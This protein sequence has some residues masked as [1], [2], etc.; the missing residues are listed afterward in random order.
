MGCQRNSNFTTA[1]GRNSRNS[2]GRSRWATCVVKNASM[3]TAA[4]EM[5]SHFTP[6][7]KPGKY[8]TPGERVLLPYAMKTRDPLEQKDNRKRVCAWRLLRFGAARW[9]QPRSLPGRHSP[10]PLAARARDAKHWGCFPFAGGFRE[11]GRIRISE[12][13]GYRLLPASQRVWRCHSG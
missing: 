6:F 11:R 2:H 12:W 1:A 7:G 13:P 3:K 8:N 10:A 9:V 4:L 5:R